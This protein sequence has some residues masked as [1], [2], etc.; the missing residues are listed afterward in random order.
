MA[1]QNL[2]MLDLIGDIH[3]HADALEALLS[4]LGYVKGPNGY[5]HSERKVLFIGDYIDRGPNI[6]RTLEIVKAMVDSGNAIALMGNHEYNAICFHTENANGGHL[7][8]HL[9]KNV[10]QHIQTLLQFQNRQKEYDA[11]IEWFK[12]LPLWYEDDN[13]RAI[14]ACWD[15][16]KIRAF[17]DEQYCETRSADFYVESSRRGSALYNMVENCLKGRELKMPDGKTFFD[18]DGNERSK[19]RIKWWLDPKTATY[20][21]L[22]ILDLGDKLPAG[23]VKDV[24]YEHYKEDQK[25]VFFGHYWLEGE[26][27]L[28]RGNICCLDWSIAKGGKLAAYCYDGEEEL[29]DGRF[30]S[31]F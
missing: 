15:E 12:T 3:G 25:P 16:E 10:K 13:I 4:K 30:T 21:E 11:Y 23:L 1:H 26:P 31:V 19:I 7:R 22:S 14:H 6:P 24:A 9:I 18:K 17:K 29:L 28:Y 8:K 5:A 27:N 2:P 20:P